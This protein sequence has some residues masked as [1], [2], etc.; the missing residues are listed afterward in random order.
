M[1]PGNQNAMTTPNFLSITSLFSA[2]PSPTAARRDL[3]IRN[4]GFQVNRF[5]TL[6]NIVIT[7]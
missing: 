3:S 7:D 1:N 4:Q 5:A 6:S 2:I